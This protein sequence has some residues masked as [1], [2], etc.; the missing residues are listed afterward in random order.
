MF[1]KG[2]PFS[3]TYSLYV[4][5]KKIYDST[6]SIIAYPYYIGILS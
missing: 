1:A 3:T 4:A 2:T 6:G 5:L